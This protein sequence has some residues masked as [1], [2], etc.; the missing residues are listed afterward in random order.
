M[1]F[2]LCADAACTTGAVPFGDLRLL[3]CI[4]LLI[5]AES[6]ARKSRGL[7]VKRLPATEVAGR[8]DQK[9]PSGLMS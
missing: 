5:S 9:K 1:L 2:F 6:N 4:Q 8:N 7:I 3:H